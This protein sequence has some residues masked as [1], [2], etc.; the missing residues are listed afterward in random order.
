MS[1]G[2]DDPAIADFDDF[3][4]AYVVGERHI[5]R[6]ADSLHLVALEQLRRGGHHAISCTYLRAGYTMINAEAINE[7]KS[8]HQLP[9]AR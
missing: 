3:N 8:A 7:Q 5:L 2:G 4:L 6:Q 9:D 1:D